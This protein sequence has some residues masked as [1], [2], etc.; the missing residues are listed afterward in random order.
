MTGG[1]CAVTRAD[2]KK[3]S[4]TMQVRAM[5]R[6]IKNPRSSGEMMRR[7]V[8]RTESR[9]K[10]TPAKDTRSKLARRTSRGERAESFGAVRLLQQLPHAVENGVSVFAEVFHRWLPAY[11][12]A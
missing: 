5:K 10:N 8:V 7:I 4:N 1:S 3:P 6:Y 9:T 2:V 11:L 12:N